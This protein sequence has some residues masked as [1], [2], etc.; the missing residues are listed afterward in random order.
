MPFNPLL[1]EMCLMLVA[2][3]SNSTLA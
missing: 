3:K 1:H 2:S